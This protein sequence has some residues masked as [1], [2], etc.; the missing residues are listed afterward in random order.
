M[1]MVSISSIL[2]LHACEIFTRCIL[3][4]KVVDGAATPVLSYAHKQAVVNVERLHWVVTQPKGTRTERNECSV[5][6][7]YRRQGGPSQTATYTAYRRNTTC[8]PQMDA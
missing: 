2:Q 5:A 3:Q 8:I 1:R 7:S 6:W 4:V